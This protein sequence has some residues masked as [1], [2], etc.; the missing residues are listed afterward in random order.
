MPSNKNNKIRRNIPWRIKSFIFRL[1]DF[2]N[3]P[4]ILYFLQKNITKRSRIDQINI[5]PTWK[6]HGEI[7]KKYNATEFIF[8]FGAGKNLAQNL[9]LSSFVRKQLVVDLNPMLDISLVENSRKLISEKLSLKSN[10]RILNLRS[11]KNYGIEYKAPY[12]A[13]NTY[14]KDQSLDAC[15][16]TN[17]LE[18]IPKQ[19]IVKIFRE[20]HRTLKNTGIASLQIDKGTI[21]IVIHILDHRSYIRGDRSNPSWKVGINQSIAC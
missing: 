6:K 16:S 5:S 18:H 3:T 14:L 7:L 21:T 10:L 15:I 1:I 2:F 4:S 8:E 17:T 11:L 9:F 19:S 20:L 13:E 12:N